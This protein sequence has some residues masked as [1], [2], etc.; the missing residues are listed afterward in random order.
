MSVLTGGTGPSSALRKAVLTTAIC[1]SLLV[2]AGCGAGGGVAEDATVSVYVAAPLCPDAK[3]KHAGEVRVRVVC[4]NPV[5]RGGSL[6]LAQVGANARRATEDSA[7]VAYVEQAGPAAR[8]S[9]PIVESAGIAYV[10]ASSGASAMTRL[11]QAIEDSSSVS[12]ESVREAL[13]GP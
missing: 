3:V 2:G 7:S 11:L 6:D 9:R 12:R 1:A 8:F 4:L 10:N 5:E 13:D